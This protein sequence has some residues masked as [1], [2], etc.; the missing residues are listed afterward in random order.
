MWIS[1]ASMYSG[2]SSLAQAVVALI[3]VVFHSHSTS[4]YI[5]QSFEPLFWRANLG[6][7]HY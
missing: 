1:I 6:S 4:D 2:F 7:Q 3:A 5:L